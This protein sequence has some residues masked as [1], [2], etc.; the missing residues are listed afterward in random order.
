MTLKEL[1]TGEPE[2]YITE[3]TRI[4]IL[5]IVMVLAAGSTKQVKAQDTA[6]EVHNKALVQTSFDAW[7]SGNGSPFD[8]LAENASW[9]IT[10]N[11]AAA[12]TYP[13]REAFL[14]AVIRPFNS[15]MAGHL[16]PTVRR[17]Y[18]DGDTVIIL[19]DAT[20][21]ARDGKAYNNSYAWFLDLRNDKVVRAVAFFDSFEF[22]AL[23]KRVDPVPAIASK[24]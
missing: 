12:G 1:E 10:G 16:T 11:S 19:F 22:D 13:N 20:G 17:T 4:I 2:H 21:T 15:R 18:A 24:R 6:Q 3:R 14:N 23:W 5:S 7:K 8:L 9:T